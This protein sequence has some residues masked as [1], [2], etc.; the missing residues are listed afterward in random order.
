MRAV[1]RL[2]RAV[3]KEAGTSRLAVRVRPT[4]DPHQIV[5]AFP[6][7]NR[8][9]AQEMGRAVADVLDAVTSA[10]SG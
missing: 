5:V 3:A 7:R 4:S 1:E 2:V 10:E 8:E 6:W 9:R